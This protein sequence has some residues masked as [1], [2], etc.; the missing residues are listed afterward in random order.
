MKILYITIML[1]TILASFI[2]ASVPGVVSSVCRDV[3][4]LIFMISFVLL[5]T[6]INISID[7]TKHKTEK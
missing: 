5:T 1:I 2:C 7:V 6:Y 4:G 3:F